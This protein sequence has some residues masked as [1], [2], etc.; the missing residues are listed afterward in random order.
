MVLGLGTDILEVNRIKEG[1][2]K[3]GERYLVKLFTPAEI[4]YCLSKA[5]PELHLTGRF[6][7]KEAV[8]KA[9]SHVYNGPF[10]WTEIEIRNE[11]SGIP[12][13]FLLDRLAK[14]LP[15]DSEIVIS[16]SHTGHSAISVAIIQK[17]H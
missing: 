15:S 16:I 8:V 1:Y 9:L 7:A 2:E 11:K 12:K 4:K 6:V 17:T 5:E 3:F 14:V 10:A 13:V